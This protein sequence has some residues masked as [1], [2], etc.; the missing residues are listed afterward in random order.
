MKKTIL[1]LLSILFAVIY[2]ITNEKTQ[3]KLA[4]RQNK[5]NLNTIYV[6]LDKTLKVKT[7]KKLWDALD[8]CAR[9]RSLGVTG[10]VFVVRKEDKK[11]FWDTSA[12]VQNSSNK[13]HLTKD[14]ICSLFKNPESCL[15]GV[16][17]MI[18]EPPRGSLKW[19]FDNS[20][21]YLNY[22]YLDDAVDGNHYIIVQGTQGDEIGSVFILLSSIVVFFLIVKAIIIIL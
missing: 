22:V 10:D 3:Q 19:W 9:T 6:C 16:E 21:E 2:F 7:E 11:L 15:D 8:V 1:I 4:E 12:D 5:L 14:E 18:N 13:S 20:T 17:K